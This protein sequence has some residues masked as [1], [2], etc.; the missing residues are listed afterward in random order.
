MTNSVE[1]IVAIAGKTVS[2]AS[3]STDFPPNPN[4]QASTINTVA[5]EVKEADGDALPVQVDVRSFENVQDMV[6]RVIKV[7]AD[8]NRGHRCR[9]RIRP[10]S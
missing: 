10:L 9:L 7:S 4:S 5:R 6:D 8:Q 3:A 2:D 1:P